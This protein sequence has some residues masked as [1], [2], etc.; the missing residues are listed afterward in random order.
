MV[1]IF[2]RHPS[3]TSSRSRRA[4]S[5]IVFFNGGSKL[6]LWS[7]PEGY[8][9]SLPK[10]TRNPILS[11]SLLLLDDWSCSRHLISIELAESVKQMK[12]RQFLIRHETRQNRSHQWSTRPAHSLG[13]QWF[14]AWFWNFWTDGRTTCVK[15]VITSGRDSGRP[16]GSVWYLTLSLSII[17]S[18][19]CPSHFHL[20]IFVAIEPE[21]DHLGRSQN[22]FVVNLGYMKSWADIVTNKRVGGESWGIGD[23]LTTTIWNEVFAIHTLFLKQLL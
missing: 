21:I 11:K 22:I 19:V 5:S 12:G 18:S 23:G 13:R 14:L 8:G 20:A 17:I 9:C 4:Q 7:E 10:S 6:K 15:T 3:L 1:K 2:R 16:R